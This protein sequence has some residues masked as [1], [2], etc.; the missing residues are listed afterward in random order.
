VE[1][2]AVRVTTGRGGTWFSVYHWS[3]YVTG[4]D[5]WKEA[6]RMADDLRKKLDVERSLRDAKRRD[7]QHCLEAREIPEADLD[8]WRET[9][10]DPDVPTETTVTVYP[11][12]GGF[13]RQRVLVP[14]GHPFH[15]THQY[16]VV[17]NICFGWSPE[18][19]HYHWDTRG[20]GSRCVLPSLPKI[21][22]AELVDIK[23]NTDVP[24]LIE[25]NTAKEL[26]AAPA[27]PWSDL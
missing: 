8:T 25:A 16:R 21:P 12:K 3:N 7:R 17:K 11:E 1:Q 15:W 27:D 18:E 19:P 20:R 10:W 4:S 22:Y 14:P 26:T 13:Y 24:A 2:D 23:A 6:Y 5:D 9:G